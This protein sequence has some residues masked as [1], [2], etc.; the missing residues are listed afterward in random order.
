LAI[1]NSTSTPVILHASA[2]DASISQK[3][4]ASTDIGEAPGEAGGSGVKDQLLAF[5]VFGIFLSVSLL[6]IGSVV[7]VAV[8][9][10]GLWRE[11]KARPT[12]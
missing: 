12:N 1:P 11:R 7:L 3:D 6:A 2:L 9:I 8:R 5:L 10:S 4:C